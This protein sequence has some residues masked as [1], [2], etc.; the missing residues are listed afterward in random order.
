M[1]IAPGV[2]AAA[3]LAVV[4]LAFSSGGGVAP[5]TASAASV[6]RASANALERQAPSWALGPGEYFYRR[7]A[8]W[9]RESGWPHHRTVVVKSVY[10]TWTARD[11]AG[12]SQ[13]RILDFIGPRYLQRTVL[14]RG[15]DD[16]LR[17]SR[18]PFLIGLGD[19]GIDLSYAQ[20]RD[21]PADPAALGR[22]V[23]RVAARLVR[24]PLAKGFDRTQLRTAIIFQITRSL[25]EVPATAGV[26]AAIYRLL[27]A[28]PGIRLLGRTKDAVG[29]SGVAVE[30]QAGLFT[31]VAILDPRTGRLLQSSR[32]LVHR[33]PLM[34]GYPAGLINRST[35]LQTGVV[36]STHSTP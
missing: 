35:T 29:R 4:V 23:D 36:R 27:A 8:V 7:F 22:Y 1:R 19:F 20:L 28:T 16:R 2:A 18:K 15:Y 30:A 33:T 6:L 26:R 21:L 34:P 5:Q 9:F 14:G 32:S 13:E 25:G 3:A 11:G 17:P 24:T 12:R 31:F 10:Q